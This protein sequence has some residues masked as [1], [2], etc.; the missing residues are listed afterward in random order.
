VSGRRPPGAAGI[1]LMVL[2][3]ALLLPLAAHARTQTGPRGPRALWSQYPLTLTPE[4]SASLPGRSRPAAP[5][6]PTSVSDSGGGFPLLA[7]LVAVALGLTGGMIVER[8]RRRR[9]V[10]LRFHHPSG[11]RPARP[12]LWRRGPRP[13]PPAEDVLERTPWPPATRDLWR[14]EIVWAPGYANSRFRAVAME[15]R[16]HRR[17]TLAETDAFTAGVDEELAALVRRVESRGWKPTDHGPDWWSH[18]FVWTGA[19][20]PVHASPSGAARRAAGDA[21]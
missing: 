2:C 10:A 13:R 17:R 14:C 12:L 21:R 15:P 5:A 9:P 20:P 11:P 18:R 6:A 1:T 19:E 16:S 3:L 8:R 7:V 4:R